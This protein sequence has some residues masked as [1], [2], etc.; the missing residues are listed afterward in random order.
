MHID[1]LRADGTPLG[2]RDVTVPPMSHHQE[3]GLIGRLT[4]LEV[5]NGTAVLRAREPEAAYIAYASVV[6]NRSG[7][8]LLMVAR[9]P[10]D[11]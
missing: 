8:P 9:S 3:N 4:G 10:A 7:D 2:S 11:L 5:V 6:E 1:L